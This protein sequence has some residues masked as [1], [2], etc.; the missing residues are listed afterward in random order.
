MFCD[1]CGTQLAAD[2]AFCTNCG[3]PVY[4]VPAGATG[5]AAPPYPAANAYAPPVLRRNRVA[6]HTRT[7][8]ICWLV[9]SILHLL[10]MLA[11]LSF[12][13]V[14]RG[15]MG[16]EVPDF[17][18]VLVQSVLIAIA[19]FSALGCVAGWGLLTWRPWGRM[20]AIVL[21][22]INLLSLPFGTALGI[23]TLWVLLSSDSEVDYARQAALADAAPTQAPA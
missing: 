11:A 10:P 13:G 17:V 19:A 12:F 6:E 18:P 2:Q 20:L 21:G 1:R 15:H 16:D 3:K 14:I 23:Y 8:A 7:L 5:V 22:V 4:P 9:Y